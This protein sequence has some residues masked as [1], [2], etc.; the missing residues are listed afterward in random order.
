MCGTCILFTEFPFFKISH[1]NLTETSEVSEKIETLGHFSEGFKCL[2]GKIF[3]NVVS[4]SFVHVHVSVF[5]LRASGS[6]IYFT[7]LLHDG[8]KNPEKCG[9]FLAAVTDVRFIKHGK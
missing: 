7:Y 5:V 2:T 1:K 8:S 4:M 3:E 6:V 9:V